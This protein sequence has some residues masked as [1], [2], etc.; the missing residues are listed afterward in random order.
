VRG[1]DRDVGRGTN[2]IMWGASAISI[3]FVFVPAPLIAIAGTA[4]RALFP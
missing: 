2:V 3:F 4:A 1:F